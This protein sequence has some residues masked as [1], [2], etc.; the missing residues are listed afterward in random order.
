MGIINKIKEH[1][2]PKRNEEAIQPIDTSEAIIKTQ[3]ETG[4]SAI[5]A[6]TLS[7][8][9]MQILKGLNEQGT[10]Q[11]PSEIIDLAALENNERAKI[12]KLQAKLKKKTLKRVAEIENKARIAENAEAIREASQVNRERFVEGVKSACEI[13]KVTVKTVGKSAFYLL[14]TLVKAAGEVGSA[15]LNGLAAAGEYSDK[16]TASKLEKGL[17]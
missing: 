14:K 5:D 15:A 1:L 8:G 2:S 13:G 4:T 3:E 12:I 7:E 17:Y 9:R 10:S 6:L 16:R 11:V